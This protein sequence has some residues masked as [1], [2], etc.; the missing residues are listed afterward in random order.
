[1]VLERSRKEGCGQGMSS[2]ILTVSYALAAFAA[3]AGS[4]ALAR[5]Y[6]RIPL[7]DIPNQRSSHRMPKPRSGGIAILLGLLAGSTLIALVDRPFFGTA[8]SWILGGGAAFFLLGLLDDVFCLPEWSR[9]LAQVVLAIAISTWGLGLRFIELPGMKPWPLPKMA[10]IALTSFWYVG[11]V[12]LFNFMD[13]TDGMAAGE[14]ALAGL[15]M[16]FL[17]GNLLPLL[18][19]AAAFGFLLTNYP[20]ALIFMGD[21]GS[22]LLG[23]LLAASAIMGER[24]GVPF[25]AFILVLGT[26]ITDTTVTLFRRML[27]GERWFKAHRSH[28]YQ[29]LTDLGMSHARVLGINLTLTIVLSLSAFVYVMQSALIQLGILG[30]WLMAFLC[31]IRWIH[32]QKK[33]SDLK[34]PSAMAY[35]LSSQ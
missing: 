12:N 13:G 7:V 16:A 24:S 28:Y 6:D 19:S 25:V 21:S 20:P 4:W 9:L 15:A 2:E 3:A 10:S 35:E 32:R 29:K 33:P 5:W 1:M 17:G 11:F 18:V 34:R 8:T 23:F 26:F 22:Y 30:G 14:A 31:G 27:A